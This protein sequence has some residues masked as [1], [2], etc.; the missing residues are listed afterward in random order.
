M[1]YVEKFETYYNPPPDEPHQKI[2]KR[3]WHGLITTDG[4]TCSVIM[5]LFPKEGKGKEEKKEGGKG[6]GEV[7]HL[8]KHLKGLFREKDISQEE[9]PKMVGVVFFF[10]FYVLFFYLFCFFKFVFLNLFF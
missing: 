3:R 8:S 4:V 9:L 1:Y 7:V 6:E 10:L 2:P 5:D